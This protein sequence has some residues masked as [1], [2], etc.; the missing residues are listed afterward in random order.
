MIR[1]IN[2]RV[3]HLYILYPISKEKRI[4]AIMSEANI[5]LILKHTKGFRHI[6]DID[7]SHRI[8]MVYA[9]KDK[10]KII[11]TSKQLE[12]IDISTKALS[13]IDKSSPLFGLVFNQTLNS[14][15]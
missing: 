15:N 2:F 8:E 11:E 10:V 13:D 3:T 1:R 5:D 4:G 12:I 6:G 7:S 14:I 9:T